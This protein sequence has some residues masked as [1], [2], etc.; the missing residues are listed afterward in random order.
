VPADLRQLL[1][2]SFA[3]EIAER[4]PRLEAFAAGTGDAQVARR[5]AHTIGS[6]AWVVEEPELARLARAVEQDLVGGPLHELVSQLRTW[7]P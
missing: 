4:L 6:S 2:E 3:E 7:S 1:R 5:D